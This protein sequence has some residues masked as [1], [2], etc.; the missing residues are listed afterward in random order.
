MDVSTIAS[1]ATTMSST[2]TT[3]AVSVA[4]LKK[5]MDIQSDNASALLAAIPSVSS[6]NLPP[7]LGQNVNTTA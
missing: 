3:D 5:A 4:V 6:Q 2:A 7:H 1:I